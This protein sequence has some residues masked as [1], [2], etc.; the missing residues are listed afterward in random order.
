MPG[1]NGG[2]ANGRVAAVWPRNGKTGLD[3]DSFKGLGISEGK[4]LIL[5]REHLIENI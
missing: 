5:I 4:G 1:A 3:W 2:I